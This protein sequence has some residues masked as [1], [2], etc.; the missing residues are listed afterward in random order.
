MAQFFDRDGTLD[1][2]VRTSFYW[3]D[4]L[5]FF[6]H[7]GWPVVPLLVALMTNE[8]RGN[9]YLP[10]SLDRLC[11]HFE[12]KHSMFYD[13]SMET[14]VIRSVIIKRVNSSPSSYIHF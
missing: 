11:F 6:W 2:L 13:N 14:N 1:V 9:R 8:S 4:V 7:L 12:M 5:S 3:D 10:P